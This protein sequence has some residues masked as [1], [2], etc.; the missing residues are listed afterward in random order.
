MLLRWT[1]TQT[2]CL[3]DRA[4]WKPSITL[5]VKQKQRAH[6]IAVG[7]VD[8]V[9]G[10]FFMTEVKSD[11]I[12]EARRSPTAQVDDVTARLFLSGFLVRPVARR[13]PQ[14]YV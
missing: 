9:A 12:K 5:T 13:R 6:F 7:V 11:G 2:E 3:W 14:K 4:K 8:K 10:S 1:Q